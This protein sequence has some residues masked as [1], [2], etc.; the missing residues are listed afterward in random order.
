[1]SSSATARPFDREIGDLRNDLV[2]NAPLITYLRYNVD[3]GKESVHGLDRTLTD[4]ALIASLVEMDAPENM[5]TLHRLG[6]L[7]AERDIRAGDF[8]SRFDLTQA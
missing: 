4:D 2:A 7:A 6:C 8:P 5:D 3:L 1:M